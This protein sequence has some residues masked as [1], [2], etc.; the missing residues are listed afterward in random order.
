MIQGTAR[1]A[2]SL[3]DLGLSDMNDANMATVTNISSF[4]EN[5]KQKIDV[6]SSIIIICVRPVLMLA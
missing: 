6:V 1:R 2:E 5:V 4:L 3:V